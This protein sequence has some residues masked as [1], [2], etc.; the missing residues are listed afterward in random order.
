MLVAANKQLYI[1]L[2]KRQKML[3]S[4]SIVNAVRSQNPPGRFLQKD[5]KTK[6]WSDVGDQ[7]AQE[8]TSQ[9]LREGAPDIRKKVAAA[10]N[11]TTATT[12]NSATIPIAP[13]P[14]DP[15][16]SGAKRE[17]GDTLSSQIP[18][19]SLAA[20]TAA[21]HQEQTQP[22]STASSTMPSQ[23]GPGGGI[24]HPPTEPL[25]YNPQQQQLQQRQQ[26]NNMYVGNSVPGHMTL[27]ERGIMIRN[28]MMNGGGN[29]NNQHPLQINGNNHNFEPS[30]SNFQYSPQQ[31]QQQFIQQQQQYQRHHYDNTANYQQQQQQQNQ[32]QVYYNNSDNSLPNFDEF[33]APPP[34][35]LETQGLS[36]GSI[37]MTDVEVQQLQQAG[38]MGMGKQQGNRRHSLSRQLPDH[39]EN[40]YGA[41]NTRVNNDNDKINSGRDAMPAAPVGSVLEP[42]GSSIGDASMMSAGTSLIMKLEEVGTSFGTM[43]SY[44][45]QNTNTTTSNPSMVDGGL[46]DAVGTSFGSMSLD[47]NNRDH[48]FKALEITAGGA[49]VPPFFRNEVKA[50]GNLLDCSDTESEDS[51]EKEKL[52][53]QKSQAWEMMKTQ[54]EKQTSKGMSVG[55][56][57]LMPPPVGVPQC[58]N[59]TNS[60]NNQDTDSA[61]ATFDNI[62]IALPRMEPN[63]STLSAW[64]A[65]DD[66][67]E[68]DNAEKRDANHPSGGGGE[69]DDAALSPPPPQ[70][71]KTESY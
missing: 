58:G 31:Q 12:N 55:S 19:H 56:Q 24:I 59:G 27:D 22:E 23:V 28:S 57:E 71:T 33:V 45:T 39:Q 10:K 43:M 21:R 62:E 48:L 25:H 54:L 51:L 30:P 49:E 26:M 66:G 16:D 8:K 46:I 53:Q 40:N 61:A 13:T 17:E 47:K 67:V 60:N 36:F 42:T 34:E 52:T 64:G 38:N 7:R 5:S 70:L 68:G 2:P 63:F 32:Q 6:L 14:G 20:S 11:Q 9:A 50:S 3:L 35:E 18:T 65:A 29:M 41:S 1:T 37:A 4:R 69:N 15:S 44:N